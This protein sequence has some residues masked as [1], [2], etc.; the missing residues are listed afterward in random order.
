MV[1]SSVAAVLLIGTVGLASSA[2]A[3]GVAP[4]GGGI[5]GAIGGRD[6]LGTTP[7][8]NR[9]LVPPGEYV[10]SREVTT[11]APGEIICR[12]VTSFAT[13]AN[14]VDALGELIG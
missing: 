14:D 5:G 11:L 2:F 7:A 13:T 6:V 4:N 12:F 9:I 3:Q 8:D 1:K 10:V